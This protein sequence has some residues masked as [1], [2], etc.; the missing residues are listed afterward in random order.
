MSPT[1]TTFCNPPITLAVRQEQILSILSEISPESQILTVGTSQN[2]AFAWLINVDT[3]QVCPEDRLDVEQRYVMALNYFQLDGDNWNV[4]SAMNSPTPSPCLDNQQRHLSEA[5]VCQWFNVSCDSDGE[6]IISLAFNNNNLSGSMPRELSAL[7]MIERI[8]YSENVGISGT[9]PIEYGMLQ[10]L[11]ELILNRNSLSGEIP[12]ELCGA[13]SLEVID[14][15]GNANLGGLIPS[16]L[17]SLSSLTILSLDNNSF[18]G[19]VPTELSSLSALG[20]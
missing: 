5:N 16:C 2:D 10:T 6:N 20:K 4:C 17:G 15:L 8:D 14:F 1:Q 7:G 9:I 11:R 19:Q 3:A 18:T 12:V 13:T